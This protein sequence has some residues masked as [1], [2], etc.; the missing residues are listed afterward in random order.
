MKKSNRPTFL[1]VVIGV[2][3]VSLISLGIL[4]FTVLDRLASL[5]DKVSQMSSVVEEI[6]ASASNLVQQSMKL[7]ETQKEENVQKEAAAVQEEANGEAPQEDTPSEGTL[8]PSNGTTFT[9]NTDE[10]MDQLLSQVEQLLPQDNGTWS[11]YVCNLLKKSDGTINSQPMKAASLIKL[12]I[13]GAVY[14]NYQSL[15]EQH[16]REKL[17]DT[18]HAMITVSDNDAANALTN[19]LGG[20]DDA[21]GRAVVNAFCQAHGYTD[22]SMGRMLLAGTENGDNYTSVRDCGKFLREVYEVSNK[23][24][25][26]SEHPMENTQAMYY[27]L[28]MQQRKN[29]IPAQMPD[30]VH[31]ANKTGELDDVENDAGIIFD[32]AKGIDLVIC[33]MS[34]DVTAPGAAQETIAANSRAIYGYYNE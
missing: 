17:D 27:H 33:F 7:E 20:G 21:Q 34:Q 28:K 1:Y 9:N 30:G 25:T 29:K 8:S 16:G 5:Q 15:S 22:T 26:E 4:T 32:T 12:F 31:V 19:W 3:A 14:E 10:S 13:M 2:L 11:V 24:P 23:L 18:I 6:S